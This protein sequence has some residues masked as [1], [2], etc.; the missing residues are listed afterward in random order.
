MSIGNGTFHPNEISFWD[1]S[2]EI[3]TT[4]VFSTGVTATYVDPD[5]VNFAAQSTLWAAY[6]AGV[7]GIVNG[8]LQKSRW[9][10]EVVVNSYPADDDI[11][12]LS[13]RE[14]KLLVQY[15]NTV[16]Q[17]KLTLTIPT[18]DVSL[19]T[20]LPQAGDFVA[21]TAG[22]GA[23]DEIVAFVTAFEAFAIDPYAAGAVQIVGLKV[24]GRNN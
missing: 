10:N 4:K 14:Q 11:N 5:V 17:R 1:K 24:V 18:L 19:V 7:M 3:G 22:Q 12:Q 21:I 2:R 15:I 13:S 20:Y 23:G 16:T 6:L 8:L 9:V